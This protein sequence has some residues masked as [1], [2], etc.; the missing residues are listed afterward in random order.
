MAR[1]PRN[2]KPRA[3]DAYIKSY[4]VFSAEPGVL[5]KEVKR[6]LGS[7]CRFTSMVIGGEDSKKP[8]AM[9][10]GRLHQELRCPQFRTWYIDQKGEALA[11]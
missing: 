5:V 11:R 2:H 8:Q 3:S 4:G 9:P 6:W 1:I 10:I 7:Y